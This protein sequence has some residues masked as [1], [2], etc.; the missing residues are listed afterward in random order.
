MHR[1]RFAFIALC[2]L[3]LAGSASAAPISMSPGSVSIET[4]FGFGNDFTLDFDGGDTSDNILNFTVHG[5]GGLLFDPDIPS[6]GLA[7]IV[8][9]GATIIDAGDTIGGG[10][11]NPD[12][13]LSGLTIPGTGFAAGLLLDAGLASSES[14]FLQLDVIPTTATIYSV[15][16]GDFAGGDFHEVLKNSVKSQKVAFSAAIPEPSAAIV[17]AVGLLVTRRAYRRR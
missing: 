3:T 1:F 4:L 5:G 16:L 2:A 10:F 13:V 8:F 15:H 11:L 14:F 12:N 17:F 7:A 6:V 9:D